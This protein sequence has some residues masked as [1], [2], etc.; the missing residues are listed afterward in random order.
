MS[1]PSE[2]WRLRQVT[3]PVWSRVLTGVHADA[4]DCLQATFA[5]LADHAHG[6]GGHLALGAHW[7]FAPRVL[8]DGTATVAVSLDERA[9]EARDDLGLRVDASWSRLAGSQVRRLA[10]DGQPLYVSADAFDLPWCPYAGRA[11]LEH[12]FLV[13]PVDGHDEQVDVVDAYHN[14]TPWGAARPGVWRPAP[15][16]FDSALT[17]GARVLAVEPGPRRCVDPADV[18]TEN[19][20][21]LV[22]ALPRMERYVAR[23]RAALGTVVGVE[24]LVLDVWLLSRQRMLHASWVDS[25][26]RA[27]TGARGLREHVDRWRDLAALTYV[28][29]RRAERGRPAQTSL[30][31]ELGHL[32]AEDVALAAQLATEVTGAPRPTLR[33]VRG[34]VLSAL[35]DVAGTR[36]HTVVEA[37]SLRDLPGLTSFRL[38]DVLDRVE[39]D[40]GVELTGD[41][42]AATNLWD[43]D[44]LCGMFARS[45]PGG[46]PR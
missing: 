18:M 23:V 27:V 30:A 42:L 44:A 11:H 13:V 19:A 20:R 16:D 5:V 10:H 14:D 33:E 37:Q 2:A 34:T 31:D 21:H 29:L 3:H 15:A 35:A 9:H 12:S 4:L 38:A 8:D 17:S 43:L 25:L 1:D 41:T 45:V 39:A 24:R 22:D 28:A 6:R 32:L 36:E 26:G 46:V 7:R 40:L